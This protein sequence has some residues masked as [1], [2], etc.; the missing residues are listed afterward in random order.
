MAGE[1]LQNL[2]EPR[3]QRRSQK[4]TSKPGAGR[5]RGP[6]VRERVLEALRK[7]GTVSAAAKRARVYPGTVRE[8]RREDPEFDAACAAAIAEAD[9]DTAD[10]AE[11]G[12]R[13]Q[14]RKGNVTAMIFTAKNRRSDRWR[15]R[16]EHT[17]PG[18]APLRVSASDDARRAEIRE[19]IEQLG[20]AESVAIK[21]GISPQMLPAEVIEVEAVEVPREAEG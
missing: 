3:E 2:P 17:G 4:G 9:E 11:Q 14:I 16:V 21:L 20:G 19:L 5:V 7:L 8:W 10:E 6:E 15:D 18:G 1:S 12:L 13:A